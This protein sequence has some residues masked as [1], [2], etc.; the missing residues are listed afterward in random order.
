MHSSGN[1]ARK[2]GKLLAPPLIPPQDDIVDEEAYVIIL[3]IVLTSLI[4]TFRVPQDHVETDTDRISHGYVRIRMIL[5]DMQG[6]ENMDRINQRGRLS[7]RGLG[8]TD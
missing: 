1:Y 6:S 2:T 7:E 5:S 3:R 8:G 4:T